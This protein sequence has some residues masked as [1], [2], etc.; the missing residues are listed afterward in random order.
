[1]K[2]I[3]LI[4]NNKTYNFDSDSTIHICTES[5]F[6]FIDRIRI[7]FGKRVLSAIE[8]YP[9]C[10]GELDA[11]DIIA[12]SKADTIVEHIFSCNNKNNL[13]TNI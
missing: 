2:N 12:H 6:S 3:K 4:I 5:R 11:T 13:V 7:L 1:M 8:V 9:R 10:I